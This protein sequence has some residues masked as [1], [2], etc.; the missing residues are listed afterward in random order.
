[1]IAARHDI[2]VLADEVY[3]LLDWRDEKID[4]RRPARMAVLGSRVASNRGRSQLGCCITVSSFTKIFAPG[5]RCGW[6][7]GPKDIID[8]LL[9]LGYIQSQVGS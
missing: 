8:S 9:S 2:L 3:H 6:I 1:M 7:E 5:V 4:G